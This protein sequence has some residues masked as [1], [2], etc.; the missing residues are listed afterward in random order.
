MHRSELHQH[1][2]QLVNLFLQALDVL[3]I[4]VE[5]ILGNGG[6]DQISYKTLEWNKS[7]YG[8]VREPQNALE[9]PFLRIHQ[10]FQ[11]IKGCTL[12]LRNNFHS[13]HLSSCVEASIPV[14]VH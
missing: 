3:L 2:A 14:E 11:Y 8:S 10:Q 1:L 4:W 5:V 12:Q 6:I 13:N 7:R 9:S